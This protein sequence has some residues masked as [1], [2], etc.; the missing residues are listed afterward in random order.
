LPYYWKPQGYEKK[1]TVNLDSWVL[2]LYKKS[3]YIYSTRILV[4]RLVNRFNSFSRA[5]IDLAKK[6]LACVDDIDMDRNKLHR[7]KLSSNHSQ[8]TEE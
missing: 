8:R 1:N 3:T 6:V 7:C 4:Y 2:L 5:E